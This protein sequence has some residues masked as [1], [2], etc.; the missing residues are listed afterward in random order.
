LV[1]LA[2]RDGVPTLYSTRE[3]AA[4]GGLASYGAD[5]N[6]AYRQ[7]GDYVGKI[8]AGARPAEMP[9]VQSTKIELVINLNTAKALGITVAQSLLL[10]ADEVIR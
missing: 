1:A 4:A 3:F 9:V 7:A 5:I 2:G 10:R 8:L 6:D